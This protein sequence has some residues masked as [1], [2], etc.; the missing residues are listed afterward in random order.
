MQSIV[1]TVVLGRE[2]IA[3]PSGV[4]A[5]RF[6]IPISEIKADPA[7]THFVQATGDL[8]M[9]SGNERRLVMYPCRSNTELNFVALHPD[10][11]SEVTSED[12]NEA[13]SKPTLLKVFGDYSDDVKALLEKVN[14]ET[15]KLWKLL[16]L[17]ALDRVSNF[18]S[19]SRF[20]AHKYLSGQSAMLHYSA[21]QHIHSSHIKARAQ[22]RQSKTVP[23]WQH[24][25]HSE[26]RL[27][28]SQ[29]C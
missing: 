9:I 13:G 20:L 2:A 1:R 29:I 15:L 8:V 14:P 16:D 6:L 19:K 26:P 11:E 18:S 28:K 21:M 7:T 17:E 10:N 4:S 3:Q 5:F 22:P 24:Y 27:R 25:S 23:Q 12:W